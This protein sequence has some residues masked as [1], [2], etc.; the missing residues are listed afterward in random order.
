[1]QLLRSSQPEKALDLLQQALIETPDQI[2]ILILKGKI[3]RDT[4]ETEY[5]LRDLQYILTLAPNHHEANL[6]LAKLYHNANDNQAALHHIELAEKAQPEHQQSLEH[7]SM[8]LGGLHRYKEAAAILENIIKNGTPH[9][10]NWNN[11]ANIY[12]GLGLFEKAERYY[13]TAIELSGD[14][15][16]AYNNY[17]SFCHYIPHYPKEKILKLYKD[18]EK[19][20]A[21]NATKMSHSVTAL[22]A[23][24]TLRI[25]MISDGFRTHPV[26]QMI[27]SALEEI[28]VH[29]IEIYA[30]STNLSED[31][32]T[33][34]IK[35][36][37]AKWM[38]VVHLNE[39]KLTCQL[40]EDK[41][42][43]LFDLCGHNSGSNMLT[44]AMKPAPLLVKWVGGLIN[45]TGLST[46]DY[47]LS[48]N[49]ETPEGKDEFYTEKLIRM[50]DDYI[51]YNSPIY[52]PD[53]NVPPAS[54][55]GY[56]TL[57]C[58]NN[59]TKLNAVLLEKWAS[60]M[61]T[62]PNSR[63]LLKGFQF[64]STT[65]RNNI[66]AQFSKLDI[67]EDRIL[68]EGP[69]P[70]AELLKT[71]N[72]I[73]IALDPWPYS[74]GLTT[75][76]AMYMGVP[77]VTLPG[78]TFAGRHSATHLTNVGL[79]QL[80]AEDW[81]QY[82]N[83]VVNLARD[84]D[85]LANI[86]THL[87]TALLES[88]VCDAPRFARNFSNAMRAIW[89]RHCEGKKPAALNLDK[90]GNLRFENENEAVSLQ[91]PAEPITAK[92]NDDFRFRFDGK[93]TVIDNGAMLAATSIFSSLHKLNILNTICLDPGSKIT[94]VQQL[95]HIGEF[96][97][98]PM[99]ILGDGKATTLYATL[100]PA[101]SS[102]LAPI[103]KQST[104]SD[105]EVIAKL[106]INSVRLDDVDALKQLDWIFLDY[107]HSIDNALKGARNKIQDAVL[108]QVRV[109]FNNH[110]EP[111][112]SLD[113]ITKSLAKLGF[114]FYDFKNKHRNKGYSKEGESTH[115]STYFLS[116]T[117]AIFIPSP[118]KIKK[119][120]K[121]KLL[122]LA[123]ISHAYLEDYH[124]CSN[125]LLYADEKL[126]L[127]YEKSN[128]SN[129]TKCNKKSKTQTLDFKNKEESISKKIDY[130]LECNLFDSER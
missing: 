30:Y 80:V 119:L 22:S 91:M 112:T 28:P 96:Y 99:M 19:R 110:Y 74:G 104:N 121:N 129:K 8:I 128:I 69:S 98:Y 33:Q 120:D 26:G 57:G 12:K 48:D 4:G 15:Y 86:R 11:L 58:F 71:Y 17:L 39:Q 44:M 106:P 41:I 77:V 109:N 81:Q 37:S 103:T 97:H 50:P 123:F 3:H 92:N 32:V 1:M 6:E 117:D 105:S 85:N 90:K 127:A 122:K 95:Q 56:I 113:E 76:E 10:F 5:A 68:L 75:C 45:T 2:S 54:Y 62:L 9:H 25:G 70:H 38:T 43:I 53:I 108:I 118:V 73:D 101:M 21:K 82:H 102:T 89:Q 16:I 78:P 13:L 130:I 84:L 114:S 42:D 18:W 20:Y 63:L 40:V 88:P 61:H 107:K 29:E 67:N 14:N 24:K 65:L 94:N 116:D 46:M 72:K 100:A 47:L 111:Q 60:I 55:N 35:N 125:V 87:R 64:S 23:D 115:K 36:L 27:T 93:I 124:L 51:C 52:T 7:K 59:P 49:I 34:R 126:C 79:G 66:K 31:A 83:I